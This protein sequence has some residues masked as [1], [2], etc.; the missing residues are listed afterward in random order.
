MSFRGDSKLVWMSPV[1][2]FMTL[3]FTP[4]FSPKSVGDILEP[5]LLRGADPDVVFPEE[6]QEQLRSEQ[7][8]KLF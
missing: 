6:L 3:Y 2:M 8:R 7:V 1:W 4:P 5:A